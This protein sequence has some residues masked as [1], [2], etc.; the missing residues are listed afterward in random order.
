MT[1]DPVVTNPD[2]YRVVWEN[3]RVRVLEYRDAPG[4]H[5]TPHGHPDSEMITLSSVS[6][7]LVSGERQA[8]VQLERG[9]ATWL[10]AQEHSGENI[11]GTETHVIFV[12]LKEPGTAQERGVEAP[13]GPSAG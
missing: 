3:E 7:R 4:D 9:V 6:R 11:G 12:E 8:D 1:N 2:L 13:L 10:A 5:T